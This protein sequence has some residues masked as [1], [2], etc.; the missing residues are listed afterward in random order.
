MDAGNE[1]FRGASSGAF[2]AAADIDPMI[3]DGPWIGYEAAFPGTWSDISEMRHD[4][5]TD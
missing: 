2:A 5:A 1:E 3:D 4:S